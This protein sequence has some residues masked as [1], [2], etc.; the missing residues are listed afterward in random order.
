MTGSLREY[1]A[2]A[3]RGELQRIGETPDVYIV[4]LF[5]WTSPSTDVRWSTVTLQWDTEQRYAA[6]A[7]RAPDRDRPALRWGWEY[8]QRTGHEIWD[9]DMDPEGHRVFESWARD[10]GLWFEGDRDD[11]GDHERDLAIDLSDQLVEELIAIVRDLHADGTVALLFGR[12]IP[13]TLVSHDSHEPYPEWSEQANPPELY[14]QF[15]P[16][17]ES[18]WGPG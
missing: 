18:I 16:Y 17:Y 7:I 8:L 6:R 10:Q 4:T 1:T 15:G 2:S 9:P 12:A 14:A 11:Y 13:I 3:I 5:I